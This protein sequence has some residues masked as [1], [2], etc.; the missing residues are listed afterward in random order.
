MPVSTNAINPYVAPTLLPSPTPGMVQ[1]N[2]SAHFIPKLFEGRPAVSAF[3]FPV[4][5][6]L[7]LRLPPRRNEKGSSSRGRHASLSLFHMD[8]IRAAMQP[9]LLHHYTRARS[10]PLLCTRL[11]KR[12]HF[13][14]NLE[15]ESPPTTRQWKVLWPQLIQWP[16]HRFC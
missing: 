13:F 15:V 4:P 16:S 12:K 8:I 1:S 6:N 5:L 7:P 14:W 3:P 2:P 9:T 11:V 10:H